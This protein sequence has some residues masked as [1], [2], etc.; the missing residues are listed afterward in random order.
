[1]T[2]FQAKSGGANAALPARRSSTTAGQAGMVMLPTIDQSPR[3][4]RPNTTIL[5]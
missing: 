3:A 5:P 2:S 1:M 4:S